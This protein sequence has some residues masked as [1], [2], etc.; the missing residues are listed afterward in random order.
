MNDAPAL[1][2][3]LIEDSVDDEIL[4]IRAVSSGGRH[5]THQRVDSETALR[6]ALAESEWD[7]VVS[8]YLLPGFSGLRAIEVVRELRHP[9]WPGDRERT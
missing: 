8:D 9:T 1:R 7:L 3:L 6:A 4:L 5:V 2:L